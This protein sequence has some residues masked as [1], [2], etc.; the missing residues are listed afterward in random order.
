MMH[1]IGEMTI[2][3]T[4]TALFLLIFKRI[5][6][7]KLSA[8]WQVWIWA[9][10][11]VRFAV[12]N[13][14]ASEIS[15]FNAIS[16]SQ[17]AIMSEVEQTVSE[18]NTPEIM[19]ALEKG[20]AELNVETSKTLSPRNAENIILWIWTLGTVGFILYFLV[21]YGIYTIK[22]F[23]SSVVADENIEQI[24]EECKKLLKIRRNVRVFSCDETPALIGVIRPR[25]IIP[26]G[27]SDEEIKNILIHELCH[28]KGGDVFLIWF[29][30]FVL[31]LNWFNPVMWYS[32]FVFRRDIEVYC[33]SRAVK[34]SENKK[35]YA[36]LLLKTALRKNRFVVGT[37]SLQ[38]GEK[39]VERRIKYMAQ[40]KK[41]KALWSA[42]L[43]IIAIVISAVCLTN[44][45]SSANMS[46]QRLA[47]FSE[48]MVGSTMADIAYADSERVVFY[49]INGIFVYDLDKEEITN[50]FDTSL[51]NCAP[52]QQGS[53]G[54]EITVTQDGKRAYLFNYGMEDE[55]GDF[56]NYIINLDTGRVKKTDLLKT[57]N[58]FTGRKD[59][60]AT[61]P[62]AKGWFSN[63]C[64][65]TGDSIVYLTN[66]TST[67]RNMKIVIRN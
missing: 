7:N 60:F 23:R 14:P 53:F 4:V 52:H 6:K 30:T 8:K 19:W 40:F 18:N 21:I 1:V 31:C 29:A 10:L 12:P 37:T 5:F 34:Y 44:S 55:I 36:T 58:S 13:L 45:A 15:V 38:N 26:E 24:L 59:S 66:R 43:A 63:R 3:L 25:I 20:E 50:A 54:L 48:K 49:Y 46:K 28:L 17:S 61:I 41:P 39:E 2:Y 65:E 47:E 64:V 62:D 67:L 32:F 35:D 51:L 56:D 33:D 16:L 42:A 57:D 27:Y 9:L 22:S 11:L